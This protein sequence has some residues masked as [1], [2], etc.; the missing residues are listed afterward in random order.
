MAVVLT[1]MGEDGVAGLRAVQKA[2]GRIL[3]QDQ[4]SCVVFGM[5]GAAIANGLADQVLPLDA[6][7]G[8]LV[9]LV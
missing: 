8:R 3:A 2:G 4:K 1:G 9:E 6:I 7:A 5:P